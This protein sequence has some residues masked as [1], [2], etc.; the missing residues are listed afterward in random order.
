MIDAQFHWHPQ[1]FCELHIGRREYPRV[2]E[3]ADGY[4]YEVS[5]QETW[6]FTREFVDLDFALQR[7]AEVGVTSVISSPAI[8]GDVGNRSLSDA[9][10]TVELLNST[11]ARAQETHPDAFYGLAVLPMQ[12]TAAALAALDRA[13]ALGL[14]GICVFSN[15]NGADIADRRLWPLY[16]RVEQLGLPVFL[17]PTR[18]L[19]EPRAAAYALERPLGYMFD[20]S[21]ATLSLIV[22]GLMDACPGL[23]FVH[24]HLGGTLPF[25]SGRIETYRRGNLWPALEAPIEHYLR[26][27]YF[28]T[29]SGTPGALSLALALVDAD[30]LLFA[31]DWPYFSPYES[32]TF[33]RQ[34][35]PRELRPGVFHLNAAKLLGLQV[36]EMELEVN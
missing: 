4:L 31:T 16:R 6:S 26:R 13:V 36:R 24:P 30:H 33:V 11:A 10:E 15:I 12:D 2:R 29:V 8:G 1:E 5:P 35:L 22:S 28:D 21:I 18:C 9:I 32:V 14:Y 27:L 23:R 34:H 20:T 17:H 19:R 25:L 3:V 7:V